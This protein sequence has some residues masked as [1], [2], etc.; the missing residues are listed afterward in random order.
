MVPCYYIFTSERGKPLYNSK[1][2]PEMA[3]PK[4]SI[5]KR[6]HCTPLEW[7]ASSSSLKS[8]EAFDGRWEGRS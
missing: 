2:D 8:G 7:T 1:N 6:Y 3:G 5:V 4:V